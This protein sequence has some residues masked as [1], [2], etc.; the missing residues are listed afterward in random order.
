MD[1]GQV[2]THYYHA[3]A[4]AFGGRLERPFE[5]TLPVLA[6]TSLPVVG[7]Y[8]SARHVGFQVGEIFSIDKAYT[9]VAGS[10]DRETGNFTTLVTSVIEGLNIDNVLFAER[11]AVQISTDHPPD[12]YY[13]KV[14]FTG[15]EFRG[16]R[17]GGADL[18]PVLRLDIC[19][20]EKG[21]EF[22][23]EPYIKSDKL[24][25]F[26]R[27]QSRQMSEL[28]SSGDR[29][30]QPIFERLLRRHADDGPNSDAEIEKRGN[31]IVSVVDGIQ[32]TGAFDG[33]AAGH[34]LYLPE[35]GRVYLGELIVNQNA[36]DLTMLRVD[37]GC[38]THGKAAGPHGGA[39]GTSSGGT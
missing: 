8:A 2:I 9:Q 16:L 13:P 27:E 11:I 35:F 4:D 21:E 30:K 29:K 28:C 24:K 12:G 15:T 10:L 32:V 25:K 36:F 31:V 14:S 18:T 5:L 39:N 33:V 17:A 26:A 19:D 38:A 37:L 3:N 34:A 23:R 1:D 6:P 7:G 20:L 22:P